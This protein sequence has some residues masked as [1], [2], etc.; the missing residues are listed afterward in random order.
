VGVL[1]SPDENDKV[2]VPQLFR[3]RPQ[4]LII[5][6]KGVWG[7]GRKMIEGAHN[8]PYAS[9]RVQFIHKRKIVVFI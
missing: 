6:I 2:L 1:W 7:E 5:I 9:S 4:H 8:M 3:Q